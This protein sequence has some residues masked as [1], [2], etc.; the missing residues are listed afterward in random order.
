MF[1]GRWMTSRWVRASL[2]ACKT[3][4]WTDFSPLQVTRH[5]SS[6]RYPRDIGWAWGSTWR[7]SEAVGY[8]DFHLGKK[9]VHSFSHASREASLTWKSLV[10][11]ANAL[12][13]LNRG[14]TSCD[15]NGGWG[16]FRMECLK[17]VGSLCPHP[18]YSSGLTLF[19]ISNKLQ[20]LKLPEWCLNFEGTGIAYP[21]SHCQAWAWEW[22]YTQGK[23]T[24]QPSNLTT[25][26]YTLIT[27]PETSFPYQDCNIAYVPATV[28]KSAA[29]L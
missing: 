10:F 15:P 20:C 21:N 25:F 12:V 23:P 14:G 22:C 27:L 2:L 26:V 18:L 1:A 3:P 4:Q 29:P 24:T 7:M 5:H 28:S 19:I 6:Q 11:L 9:S 13:I 8:Y 17:Y 16:Q